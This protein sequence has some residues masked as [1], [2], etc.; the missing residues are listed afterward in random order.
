MNLPS[1]KIVK[2]WWEKRHF[3][4]LKGKFTWIYKNLSTNWI[5]NQADCS[6]CLLSSRTVFLCVSQETVREKFWIDFCMRK[7]Q[8]RLS[9]EKDFSKPQQM[10]VVLNTESS[11]FLLVWV[12]FVGGITLIVCYLVYSI[13]L[14]PLCSLRHGFFQCLL[15]L[16]ARL[17]IESSIIYHCNYY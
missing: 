10:E 1:P 5:R 3:P 14:I 15:S 8:N 6:Y 7:I 2:W 17:C 13:K 4:I 12:Y 16:F 9:P 11:S